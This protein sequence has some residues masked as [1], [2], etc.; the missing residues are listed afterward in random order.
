MR[1]TDALRLTPGRVAAFVGAGGKTA[2]IARIVREVQGD[3]PLLVTTSTKIGRDQS[4]IAGVHR[5]IRRTSDLQGLADLLLARRSVLLTGPLSTTEPKWLGLRLED[6]SLACQITAAIG[7]STL[8]E[9]D[10]ARNASLKAP[11]ENEPVIPAEAD[12]VVPVAGLDAIGALLELPVVHRPE[13]VAALAGKPVGARI[14]PA[15]IVRVLG[16]RRGG[17]KGIPAAAEVRVLLNKI[18]ALAK[19]ADLEAVAAQLLANGAIQAV[20]SA[21][22]SAEGRE[23]EVHAR[24]AGV[25]LAA[26][27]SQRLGQA[28]QLLLWRGRPLVWHALQAARQGGLNPIVVV[29]GAQ[30]Q[31]IRAALRD[32][33]ARIVDNPDWEQGQSTSLRRG[34]QAAAP[35]AEAVVFL[36][37]D[38]PLVDGTLVRELRR[39]HARNPAAIVAPQVL[40]RWANPVLFD[41]VTFPALRQV[42]GDRGGRAVFDR[43]EI[44]GVPWDARILIDVDTPE[45]LSRLEGLA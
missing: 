31:E 28:K 9:A 23:C 45:D 18:D 16:D 34:L 24:V 22:A 1:L 11:G 20:V 44:S 30:A 27:G 36:L 40:G 37:S 33:P 19:R 26:G 8:V 2:A 41:R 6:L 38:T 13:R 25:V 17:L 3:F 12:L 7:G 4:G 35:G 15:D 39:T 42:T 29:C 5:V 21:Q 43:F 14:D 10:G 32:E